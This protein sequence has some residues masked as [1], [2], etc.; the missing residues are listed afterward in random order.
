MIINSVTAI[1]F[2][3][4]GTTKKIINSIV[5]GM[6]IE[7][8]ENINLTKPNVRKE[9]MYNING[10]MVILGVPVYEERIPSLLIPF[11]KSL[12]GE[13]RPIIIIGVY[14][15][16]GEGIALNELLDLTVKCGFKAIGAGSF[17]GEH[18]FSSDK[19]PLAQ[20][21]PDNMDLQKAYEFG[22]N[23]EKKLKTIEN[24]N[25]QE[26]IIIPKGKMPI[27]TYIVPKNSA[28]LVTKIPRVDMNLCNCCF[29]CLKLC[30]MKAIDKDTLQVNNKLCLRCFS[31]VKKCVNHARKI[32]YRPEFLVSRI[33][34]GKNKVRMEPKTYL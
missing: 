14:G 10:D 8:S 12:K 7:I 28:R 2:S 21:R 25:L 26:N 20:M 34:K 5:K 15:N 18:S 9:N 30:P 3:P 22:M 1:Y 33:L 4:T 16:I 32:E 29:A 11:L 23:I 27:I 24:L 19:V 31:C 17:I 13:G 6:D